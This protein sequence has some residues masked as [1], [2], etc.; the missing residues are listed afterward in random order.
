MGAVR[1]YSSN[2]G[3]LYLFQNQYYYFVTV[4]GQVEPLEYGFQEIDFTGEDGVL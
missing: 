4:R 3:G 1:S 2:T